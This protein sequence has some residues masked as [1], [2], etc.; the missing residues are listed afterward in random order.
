MISNGVQ[1]NGKNNAYD[2]NRDQLCEAQV[3]AFTL[4]HMC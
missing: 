2:L 3:V 1:L 4:V